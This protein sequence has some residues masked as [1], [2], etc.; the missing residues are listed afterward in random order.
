MKTPGDSSP[1]RPATSPQPTRPE[2]RGKL[3]LSNG[4]SSGEGDA[5]SRAPVCRPEHGGRAVEDRLRRGENESVVAV[6]PGVDR[7]DRRVHDEAV[8]VGLVGGHTRLTSRPSAALAAVRFPGSRVSESPSQ[9]VRTATACGRPSGET[10][11]TY[12]ARDRSSISARN[13]SRRT[14]ML[15]DSRLA[16]ASKPHTAEMNHTPQ[17]FAL[18]APGGPPVASVVASRLLKTTKAVTARLPGHGHRRP[19]LPRPLEH[20][21]IRAAAL[22]QPLLAYRALVHHTRC[23]CLRHRL[24]SLDRRRPAPPGPV[25]QK[26][27]RFFM[28]SATRSTCVSPTSSQGAILRHGY[29]HS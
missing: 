19:P 20:V 29:R 2:N 13:A 10:V 16:V 6:A 27:L 25:T 15:M 17:R 3:I 14:A 24:A 9:R 23:R 21:A 28:T 18:R 5:V 12:G 26:R 8:P 22:D 1:R 4:A 11:R 7:G